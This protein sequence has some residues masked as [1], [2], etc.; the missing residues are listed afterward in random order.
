MDE[1]KL[2]EQLQPPPPPDAL[3]MREAARARL[4]AAASAP[5]AHPARRRRITIA[6]VSAVAMAAAGVGYGLTATLGG[7]AAHGAP[8]P[9]TTTAAGLTAVEGCPGMYR[10]AGALK[11]VSGTRLIIMGH[12][13]VTVAT[14]S[15]TSVTVPASGTAGDITD[16]SDVIVEG[17]WSGTTLVA[18]KV[19]IEAGLGLRTAAVAS[20]APT[21][22]SGT[23]TDVHHGSFTVAATFISDLRPIHRM[24]PVTTTN[25]TLVMTSDSASLSQLNTGVGVVAVG[26]IGPDG[27]LTASTVAEPSF[28]AVGLGLG[29]GNG[30]YKLQPSG[31]SPSEIAAAA[32]VAGA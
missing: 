16:G 19:G 28:L 8:S 18:G 31:C 20:P 4:A 26:R 22:A 13:P 32:S 21:L 29:L 5:R 23:V 15:S 11:Q 9:L 12:F 17:E 1:I 3:R 2:F 30:P 6:A 14:T 7:T 27:M 24:I 10:V 25:S